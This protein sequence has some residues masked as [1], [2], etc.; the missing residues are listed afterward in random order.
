MWIT[1]ILLE[2]I[3]KKEGGTAYLKII[4]DEKTKRK[5]VW[6]T[7]DEQKN[8]CLKQDFENT[9]AEDSGKKYKN[10]IFIS[11]HDDLFSMTEGLLLHNFGLEHRN[12]TK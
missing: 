12:N 4:L 11:G 8:G 1:N 7:E 5:T 10:I 6:I 2:K 3:R 9:E